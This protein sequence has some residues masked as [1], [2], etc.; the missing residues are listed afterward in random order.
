M[1][2]QQNRSR[3]DAPNHASAMEKAEGSRENLNVDA[4]AQSGG[5]ITNR[6]LE[7]EQEEQSEVP[8]RGQRKDEGSHA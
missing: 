6:P 4:P 8:P 1:A 5:G 2:D 3:D 7:E